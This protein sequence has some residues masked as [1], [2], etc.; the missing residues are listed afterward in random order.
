[1]GQLEKNRDKNKP[2]RKFLGVEPIRPIVDTTKSKEE[3]DQIN[4]VYKMER[5]YY[6][7]MLKSYLQGGTS[8]RY[9]YHHDSNGTRVASTFEVKQEYIK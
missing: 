3:Q 7:A 4:R 9:G 5:H 2:F 6:Q 8:F 1:M